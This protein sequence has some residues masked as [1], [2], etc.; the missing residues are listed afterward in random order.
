MQ[1]MKNTIAVI[2]ILGTILS[3]MDNLH[4]IYKHKLFQS[5]IQL[6]RLVL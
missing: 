3:I 1:L 4:M 5:S 6:L 2:Q